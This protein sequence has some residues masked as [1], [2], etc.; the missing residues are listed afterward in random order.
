MRWGMRD[1]PQLLQ[2]ETFFGFFAWC[3]RLEFFLAFEV[4]LRGTAMVISLRF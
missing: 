1:L 4:R 3:E 2:A